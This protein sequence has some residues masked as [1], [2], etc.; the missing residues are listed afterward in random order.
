MNKLHRTFI[1]HD[2]PNLTQI[3]ND[4]CR[5]YQ[6]PD[7]RK[8]PSV[9]TIMGW[10]NYENIQ[11]WR[12]S[13]GEAEANKVSARAAKRG[14]ATH[15]LCEHYLLGT[16]K[17][18]DIFDVEMFNTLIPHLDKINNIHALESRLFSHKLKTAG[19]VDCIGEYEGKLC[20]IDLK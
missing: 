7:G 8:Y 6:T 12:K 10:Y 14:T 19:T 18:P 4:G 5:L 17:Q 9:T 1:H 2:I 15:T 16:P 3:N 13:V 11:K 20:V